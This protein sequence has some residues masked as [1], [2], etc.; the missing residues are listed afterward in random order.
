MLVGAAASTYGAIIVGRAERRR[1]RREVLREAVGRARR[2][3]GPGYPADVGASL[4][5]AQTAALTEVTRLG[6]IVGPI[7][8]D[9]TMKV[10]LPW[11]AISTGGPMGVESDLFQV[12]HEQIKKGLDD[13]SSYLTLAI[14]PRKVRRAVGWRKYRQLKAGKG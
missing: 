3:L 6:V 4:A 14:G 12:Q 13:L 2:E 5:A 9:L 7:E 1:E 8:Y 11:I 10:A